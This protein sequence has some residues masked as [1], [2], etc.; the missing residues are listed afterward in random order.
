[1][2]TCTFGYSFGYH[3]DKVTENVP[4][5]VNAKQ[6]DEPAVNDPPNPKQ[7]TKELPQ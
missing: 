7:L 1:M 4:E 5:N 2:K 3:M 6:E